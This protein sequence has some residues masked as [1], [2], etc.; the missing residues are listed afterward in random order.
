MK[1][2]EK[3]ENIKNKII[4]NCIEGTEQS[5]KIVNNKLDELKQMVSKADYAVFCEK[6]LFI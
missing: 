5:M 1:K 6:I 3:I 4:E 2:Q